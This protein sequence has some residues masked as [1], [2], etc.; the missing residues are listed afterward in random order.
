MRNTID[1]FIKSFKNDFWLLRLS[2]ATLKRNV[3][4]YNNVILLI[5]EKDK[6]DFDTRD[7][8]YRTYIH[9]VTDEGVGWLQ[10]QVYKMSAHKYC[11][12]DYIMFSDSDCFF[13]HQINLQDYI[14]DDKPEILYTSWQDVGD[15]IVWKQPTEEFF[16]EP[17]EWE[18]MRRNNQIY[19]RSTLVALSEYKNDIEKIVMSSHRFSEFNVISTYAYKFEKDKYKFKNTAEWIYVPPLS[20]QTWSHSNKNGDLMHVKEYCR[21]LE[22]II[23]SFGLPLP[24]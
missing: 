6:H 12:A 16:G 21:I 1:I 11:H 13:D 5:P 17:V 3:S 10:Q 9:Y 15:A 22:T 18:M 14:V 4:G 7:L 19:H 23:I 8:P 2:L 20:I 24:E